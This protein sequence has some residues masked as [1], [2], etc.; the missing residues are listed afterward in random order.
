[1]NVSFPHLEHLQLYFHDEAFRSYDESF[2]NV[3]QTCP[4]L[5]KLIIWCD[6]E[7]L[8][9]SMVLNTIA[10][11]SSIIKLEVDNFTSIRVDANELN[12]FVG[13]R[14]LVEKLLL[15]GYRLT[16]ADAI[17]FVS[18]LNSLRQI[19]FQVTDEPERDRI[20]EELS[21]EWELN[22]NATTTTHS[23]IYIDHIIDVCMKIVRRAK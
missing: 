23:A 21:N 2:I 8:T 11:N 13:E 22:S 1:M 9:L 15:K 18:R 20:V 4:Q 14:P 6:I 12:R 3:L 17:N 5:Q 7:G 19:G 16:A 10:A